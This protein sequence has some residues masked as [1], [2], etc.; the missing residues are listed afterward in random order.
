MSQSESKRKLYYR[1]VNSKWPVGMK[2]PTAQEAITGATRLFRKA[3]GR[4]W[5]GKVEITRGNRSTSVW[6]RTLRVN[7]NEDGYRGWTEIVHGLSHLCHR[8][9]NPSDKPHSSRQYKLERDLTDYV[10]AKGFLTGSLKRQSKPKV[11]KDIVAIR[12]QRII[13][14]ETRWGAKLKRATTALKKAKR[15]RREYERRHQDRLATKKEAAA[16]TAP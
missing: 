4:P 5:R 7:P 11:E 6:G 2:P 10:L 9:L 13:E 1:V 12:L 3:M 14:R 16:E 8:M 15:E